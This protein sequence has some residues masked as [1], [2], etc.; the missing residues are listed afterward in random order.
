ME[1][2]PQKEN[3]VIRR[4]EPIAFCYAIS[5]TAALGPPRKESLKAEME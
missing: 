3:S 2:P 5:S 4:R 1:S